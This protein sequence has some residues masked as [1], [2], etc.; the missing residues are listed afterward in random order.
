MLHWCILKGIFSS[1]IPLLHSGLNC[2]Y[3]QGNF[4]SRPNKDTVYSQTGTTLVRALIGTICLNYMP[5]QLPASSNRSENWKIDMESSMACRLISENL[6]EKTV[7][8]TQRSTMK[9]WCMLQ[10]TIYYQQSENNYV[11]YK[12][13]QQWNNCRRCRRYQRGNHTELQTWQNIHNQERV[14]DYLWLLY[15]KVK[16]GSETLPV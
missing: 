11:L 8:I 7:F 15:V 12:V 16:G 6:P 4:Q 1:S 13:D 10:H 3:Q 14:L 2:K 5:K 9:S